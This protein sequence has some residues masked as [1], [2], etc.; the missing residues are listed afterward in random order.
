MI[1]LWNDDKIPLFDNELKDNCIPNITPFIAKNAISCIL[2]CPGGGYHN[3]ASDHEGV[4]IAKYLNSIG[5]SAFVL[6]YRVAPY[7]YPCGLL[8]A[9]RAIRYIRANADE[10][11]YDKDKIGILGFSA[12]GH[13]AANVSTS[14]DDETK[15]FEVGDEIDSVC[16]DVDFSVLC[17]PV[18]VYS[19]YS[20]YGSFKNLCG[21]NEKLK[22][23]LS[24][25]KRVSKKTPKTFIWTTADDGAVPALNTILYT[26]KLAENNVEFESHIFRSGPHG[27]G[28]ANQEGKCHPDVAVWSSLLKTWLENNGYIN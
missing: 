19:E 6:D 22:F 20:H 18:I 17:Y 1:K 26:Q 9:K 28:L 4:Q 2:V 15:E 21:D 27:L 23:S 10:Y 12:G 7:K 25:E 3:K 8:D 24:L 11:G 5:V 16:A 13:L 14:W